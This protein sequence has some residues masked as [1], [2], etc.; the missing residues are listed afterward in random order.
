MV[1]ICLSCTVSEIL[2]L[3]SQNFKR[4]RDPKCTPCC[5]TLK[6]VMPVL[7]VFS[8]QTDLKCLA[9][10]TPNMWPGPQNVEM[11][12]VTL[13]TPTREQLIMKRLILHVTNLKSLALAIADIFH[14]VQNYKMCHVTMTTPLSGMTCLHEA[15]TCCH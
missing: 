10:S 6:C 13:T 1:T 12:H 14:G 11:V 3:I 9:S 15:G 8:L 4:S 5:R 2:A 7:F